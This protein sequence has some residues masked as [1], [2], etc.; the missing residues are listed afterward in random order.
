M[1]TIKI[2]PDHIQTRAG[3]NLQFLFCHFQ[4][5]TKTGNDSYIYQ[6]NGLLQVMSQDTH[7]AVEMSG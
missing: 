3:A 7:K 4:F 2:Q 5:D 1:N 6:R